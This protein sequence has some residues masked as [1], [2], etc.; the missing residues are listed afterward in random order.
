MILKKISDEDLEA[1]INSLIEYRRQGIN[2][3]WVFGTGKIIQPLDVLIELQETRK[4]L[5]AKS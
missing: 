3:P 2:D 5:L 4:L 1:L